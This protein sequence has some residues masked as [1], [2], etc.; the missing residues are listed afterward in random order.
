MVTL[1]LCHRLPPSPAS[2]LDDV[3]KKTVPDVTA[4]FT[5]R[6]QVFE[7][8]TEPERSY[9]LNKL[10]FDILRRGEQASWD[11]DFR[12]AAYGVFATAFAGAA[13]LHVTVTLADIVK[14]GTTAIMLDLLLWVLLSVSLVIIVLTT[15]RLRMI[16]GDPVYQELIAKINRKFEAKT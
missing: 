4:P 13:A 14:K 6:R 15:I 2:Q 9:D 3:P 16:K 12:V 1:R 8:D 5:T 7:P 10:E 11:Q